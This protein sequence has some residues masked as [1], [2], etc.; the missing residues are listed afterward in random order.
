LKQSKRDVL[1]VRKGTECGLSFTDFEDLKQD[2]L[3]QMYQEI[4]KPGTL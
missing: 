3:I 1:E 2:D 4:E